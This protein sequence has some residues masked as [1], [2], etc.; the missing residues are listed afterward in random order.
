MRL[1]HAH[2]KATPFF[3]YFALH[4]THSPF[5]AP[6]RFQALYEHQSSWP[7]EQTFNAMVSVV[8]ESVGNV[9]KALKSTGM[10]D[11]SVVVWMTDNG[12]P[13]QAGGSNKPLKGGKGARCSASDLNSS[14]TQ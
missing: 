8:D 9:T 2:D 1:I 12:A 5:Q 11:N 3:M 6:H 13:V 14:M 7:L 4:N 10:W